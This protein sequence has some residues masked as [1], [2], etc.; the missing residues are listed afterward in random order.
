MSLNKLLFDF[1]DY[2]VVLSKD[3]DNYYV[4]ECLNFPGCI[5]QGK[6]KK[7]VLENIRDAIKGYIESIKKHPEEIEC[8]KVKEVIAVTV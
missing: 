4:A 3:E 1:M 6:T 7:Q 2:K 8:K 5:S